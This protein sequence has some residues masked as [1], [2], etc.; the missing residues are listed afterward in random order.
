MISDYQKAKPLIFNRGARW[1]Y[2]ASKGASDGMLI[3][4]YGLSKCDL[5]NESVPHSPKIKADS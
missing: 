1:F 2:R 5:F 4:F 3:A